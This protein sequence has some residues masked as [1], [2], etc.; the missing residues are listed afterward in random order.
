MFFF[1]LILLLPNPNACSRKK[2]P[3]HQKLSKPAVRRS[4]GALSL[5]D[6][7]RREEEDMHRRFEKES[8]EALRKCLCAT[9]AVGAGVATV[10]IAAALFSLNFESRNNPSALLQARNLGQRF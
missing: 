6:K 9:G 10:S 8:K 7:R 2:V 5:Q 4:L 1:T 3:P